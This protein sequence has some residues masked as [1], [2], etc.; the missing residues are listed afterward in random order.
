MFENQ[1]DNSVKDLK[2]D[3]LKGGNEKT[4]A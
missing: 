2:D 3:S 4:A 1:L